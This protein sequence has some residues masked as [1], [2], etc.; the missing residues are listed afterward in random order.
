MDFLDFAFMVSVVLSRESVDELFFVVDVGISVQGTAL[1]CGVYVNDI[2][3]LVIKDW[4]EWSCEQMISQRLPFYV[5][6]LCFLEFGFEIACC[7]SVLQRRY[8]ET[9]IS[10]TA[11]RYI[12]LCEKEAGV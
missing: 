6:E 4:V 1:N 5:K 11:S 12:A 8:T 3:E 7:S 2:S 10:T 9:D